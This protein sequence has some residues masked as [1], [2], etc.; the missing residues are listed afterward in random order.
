MMSRYKRRK[1]KRLRET[2][3]ER[4]RRGWVSRRA[5][6][7]LVP[8][9]EEDAMRRAV[10]DRKGQLFRRLRVEAPSGAELV[11]DLRHSA[12]GRVDQYDL[13]QGGRYLVGPMGL[14]AVFDLLRRA[15]VREGTI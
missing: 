13:L 8:E 5:R 3:R 12:A 1:M 14:T 4:A 15:A 11:F 9:D 6:M 7:Q 10:I 2:A